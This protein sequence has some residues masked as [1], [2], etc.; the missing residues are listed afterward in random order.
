MAV[1]GVEFGPDG[2]GEPP[3]PRLFTDP[4]AGLVTGE[5]V[6][7]PEAVTPV[8]APRPVVPPA[9]VSPGVVRPPAVVAAPVVRRARR[10]PATGG[11][12]PVVHAPPGQARV[13]A[14]EKGRG[15]LVAFLVVLGGLG[16]LL[17]PVVRAIID[18]VVD[19]FR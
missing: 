18:A 9:V 8:V 19:L 11:R 6:L 5:A 12:P 15:G 1:D 7:W 3:P 17:F 4:L 2:T 13:G 14:G 10:A 16:A